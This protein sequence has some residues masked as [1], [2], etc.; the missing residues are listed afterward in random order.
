V[1]IVQACPYAWDAPGGV[2]I[3][4]RQLAQHL[5]ARQHSVLVIAPSRR[6]L[7]EGGV[8]IA[9]RAVRVSYQGN[10]APIA[11]S[12]VSALLIRRAIRSFDPDVVHVHEP[13][14]P[15]TSMWV[16]LTSL[17]PVVATFHAHAERSRLYDFG[18]PFLRPVW[19]RLTSRLAVSEAARTFVSSRLDDDV[20]VVPNGVDVIPFG[21]AMPAGSLPDGRRIV[22][23]GR[24]D[25]RKGFPTA[26]RAFSRLARD[27]DDVHFVVAGDGKDR[28]A[29]EALAPDLRRRVHMLG[30][31][32]HERLPS[33]LAGADALV[34]T[35]AGQE[36]FGLVLVEAMAAG[37]PVVAT[38][39]PGY[40][41]VVRDETDGLLAAP[42]DADAVAKAL[43]R[44]LEDPALAERLATAGRARAEQFSWDVVV[45]RLEAIYQEALDRSP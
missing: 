25:R 28:D 1:R 4:V 23:V 38:D 9:G 7:E 30:A 24:L 44:V 16:T 37:V 43:R 22:W 35:P 2:Q 6:G 39:I 29:V 31:V 32:G 5:R 10:V 3:Q 21:N 33:Y 13:L 18:A 8:L 34:S 19:R 36:S 14:L 41:E 26:V 11:P 15:S 17:A 42:G 20:R 40:R 12:P 27:L 45:S